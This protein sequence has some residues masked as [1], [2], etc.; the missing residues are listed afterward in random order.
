MFSRNTPLTIALALF[1]LFALSTCNSQGER[2]FIQMSDLQTVAKTEPTPGAG[3]KVALATG[4][5]PSQSLARYR[6]ITEYLSAKLGQ[7]VELVQRKTYAEV[8]DLLR[9]GKTGIAFVCS[10]SYVIGQESFGE[11]LV[12]VPVIRGTPYYQSVI[13]VNA[14]SS[15]TQ[16]GELKGKSVALV[17]PQSTSGALYFSV[18]AGEFGGLLHL[19]SHIFTYSH[20][21]SINA[22]L[23]G[24]VDGAAVDSN[25]LAAAL[26]RDARLKTALRVIDTSPPFPNNPV[27]ASPSI[28]SAVLARA[29]ALLL[30]M[31]DD[32]DGKTAL[33]LAAIDR[34]VLLS[35]EEYKSV[36]ELVQR[37]R[38]SR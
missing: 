5:S 9:E 23:D 19:K 36:R 18:K 7:P 11:K 13:I 20:D 8:D 26:E 31:H 21:Y 2:P 24:L 30:A 35:D 28:D 29:Q 10:S 34:F 17:D 37:A 27:V 25:I 14:A 15:I 16:F 32:A 1:S 4:L 12:A 38:M 3:L 6:T 22:V 33:A